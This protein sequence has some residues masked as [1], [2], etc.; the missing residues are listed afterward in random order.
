[1]KASDSVLNESQ[2]LSRLRELTDDEWLKVIGSPIRFYMNAQ[3]E[4]SF[5]AGIREVVEWLQV[6]C[7][8]GLEAGINGREVATFVTSAWQQ[9]LREW[10]IE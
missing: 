10:S 9:Q 5:Q 4:L 7:K 6:N 2:I 8:F 1:M 3:A